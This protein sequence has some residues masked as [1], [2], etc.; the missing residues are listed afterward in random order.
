M[1]TASAR[2]G[3]LS[4]A[5]HDDVLRLADQIPQRLGSRSHDIY[6]QEPQV[7]DQCADIVGVTPTDERQPASGSGI[8]HRCLNAVHGADA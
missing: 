8:W 2:R 6:L 1:S 4:I 7:P 5:G 3:P